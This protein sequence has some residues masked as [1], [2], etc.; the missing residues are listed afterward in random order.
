MLGAVRDDRVEPPVGMTLDIGTG[1]I[2][3]RRREF[4]RD[5]SITAARQAVARRAIRRV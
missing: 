5:R 2:A 4:S 1:Q 3:H